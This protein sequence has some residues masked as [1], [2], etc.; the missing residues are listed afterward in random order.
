MPLKDTRYTE[1]LIRFSPSKHRKLL[2]GKM[3]GAE[4]F[5]TGCADLIRKSLFNSFSVAYFYF[6]LMAYDNFPLVAQLYCC[7]GDYKCISQVVTVL[8]T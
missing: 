3:L 8:S 2:K 6:S 4:L 5:P 7:C 1:P